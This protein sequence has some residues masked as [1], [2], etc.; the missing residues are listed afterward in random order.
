MKNRRHKSDS[1]RAIKLLREMDPGYMPLILLRGLFKAAAYYAPVLVLAHVLDRV[2]MGAAFRQII[3]AAIIGVAITGLIQALLALAEKHINIKKQHLSY[4]FE[5]LVSRKTMAIAYSQLESDAVKEMQS[6]IKADRSWGSGFFGVTAKLQMLVENMMNI[7]VSMAILVPLLAI[8]LK[9]GSWVFSAVALAVAA[10][11]VVIAVLFDGWYARREA[12]KMQ[13]MTET[14]KR[15]RFQYLFEGGNALSYKDMKDALL[16][17]LSGLI[18]PTVEREAEAVRIHAMGL[19]RLNGL[20]GAIRGGVSGLMLGVSYCA[21]ALIAAMGQIT[22]GSVV[23]YAQAIYRLAAGFTALLQTRVELGVDA[24]RLASTL[25]YL[26]M[27]GAADE[28][29]MQAPAKPHVFEFQNVSFTYPGAERK[30]ID[31]LD[32]TLRADCRTAIV[33]RNGSGKTTLIKLLCRLY[34]PDSGKILLDSVD[35][36]EYDE[37][38]YQSLL[39]VVFQDF[40][41]F[42]FPLGSVVASAD[43]YDATRAAD[44]LHRA[45]IRSM[46]DGLDT[47][48][49]REYA[50]NGVDVSGGEAQ[51]IAIARA[52][53]KDAPMVILDEPTAALDPKSEFEVYTGFSDLVGDKGVV[54]ISHRLASCQFCD[55]IIVMDQGRLAARGSHS[56]LLKDGGIYAC[57]WDAQAQYYAGR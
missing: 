21:A 42:S 45:G 8:T 22:V 53:Y 10:M 47:V 26:D 4:S 14:E 34:R 32:L 40:S 50:D 20:S 11:A 16:Y 57:M 43:T 6:R 3:P 49:Y 38:S 37:R 52:I 23:Q 17:R 33:G 35:I 25:D 41:L 39:A 12:E 27:G 46:P 1:R 7:L 5:T 2:A 30:A 48:L 9:G 51:K 29:G 18:R 56:A 36:W 31:G 55:D 28:S 44:A 19:S 54:Y 13:A 24:Q 15:S